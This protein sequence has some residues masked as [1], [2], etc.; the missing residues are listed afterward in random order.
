MLQFLE[1]PE[2]LPDKI[3]FT[4]KVQRSFVNPDTIKFCPKVVGFELV[5]TIF[6]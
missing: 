2:V 5:R 6:P 4:V 3:S 1:V